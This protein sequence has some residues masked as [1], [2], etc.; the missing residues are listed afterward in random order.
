MKLKK[1]RVTSKDLE[2]IHEIYLT[3]KKT[4]PENSE[5]MSLSGD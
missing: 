4:Y 5:S 3:V 1:R 2:I